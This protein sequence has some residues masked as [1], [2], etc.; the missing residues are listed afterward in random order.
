MMVQVPTD[1]GDTPVETHQT[2]IVDQPSTSKP[3]KKQKPRRKQRKEA[4]VS[5]D[6]LE[7]EDHVLTPSSDPLPRDNSRCHSAAEFIPSSGFS[8][9]ALQNGVYQELLWEGE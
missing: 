7:D 3:Q 9:K 4:E 5:N 8:T 6:K 1:I 2:P